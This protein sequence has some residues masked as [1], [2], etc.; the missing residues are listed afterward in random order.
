MIAGPN[1]DARGRPSDLN[2]VVLLA[3]D[4]DIAILQP[5]APT[6][7]E[8]VFNS[9]A[10]GPAR[11]SIGES[12]R[13]DEWI[14]SVFLVVRPRPAAKDI[15]QPPVDLVSKPSNQHKYPIAVVLDPLFR[16]QSNPTLAPIV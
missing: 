6:T 8:R 12:E 1:I 2:V 3:I 7:C 14:E 10:G 11:V 4:V 13:T 15:G 9:R 5:C 16:H